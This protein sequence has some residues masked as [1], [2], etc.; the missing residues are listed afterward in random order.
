MDHLSVFYS[1]ENQITIISLLN[2]LYL[3]TFCH[4]D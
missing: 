1:G 3:S 2:R 4:S